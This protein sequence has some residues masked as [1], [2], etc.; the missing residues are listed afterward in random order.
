MTY[1]ILIV[2]EG[3]KKK[4][5]PS[6]EQLMQHIFIETFE[7]VSLYKLSLGASLKNKKLY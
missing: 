7:A 3:G 6:I 4:R 2:T 1:D 5:H